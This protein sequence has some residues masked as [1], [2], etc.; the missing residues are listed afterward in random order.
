M[1]GD[2]KLDQLY[3]L[4]MQTFLLESEYIKNQK[5]KPENLVS[6]HRDLLTRF[7]RLMK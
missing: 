3:G 2:V 4:G 5:N 1:V 6:D 7:L